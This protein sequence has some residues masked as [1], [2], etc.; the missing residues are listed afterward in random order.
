MTEDVQSVKDAIAL[1]R[2][3]LEKEASA[4]FSPEHQQLVAEMF[5]SAERLIG[6]IAGFNGLV[7]ILLGILAGLRDTTPMAELQSIAES[8]P[9]VEQL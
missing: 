6:V 4:P 1:V 9:S 2:M 7:N 8:L 3:S 5:A